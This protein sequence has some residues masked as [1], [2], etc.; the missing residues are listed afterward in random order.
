MSPK[1]LKFVILVITGLAMLP[2]VWGLVNS[3]SLTTLQSSVAGLVTTTL[4]IVLSL[5]NGAISLD[6]GNKKLG[7]F[8]LFVTLFLTVILVA[9]FLRIVVRIDSMLP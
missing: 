4:F 8:L 7:W 3:S 9:T 5:V 2:L 1:Y 6:R